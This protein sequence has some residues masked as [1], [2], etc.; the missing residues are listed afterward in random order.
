MAPN[1]PGDVA[2]CYTHWKR[3]ELKTGI[4]EVSRGVDARVFRQ[5]RLCAIHIS[6]SAVSLRRGSRVHT[7]S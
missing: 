6:K 4:N 2:P 5:Q 1:V 3:K 7:I